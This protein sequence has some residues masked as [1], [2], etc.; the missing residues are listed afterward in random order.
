MVRVPNFGVWSLVAKLALG[1]S[2]KQNLVTRK[3]LGGRCS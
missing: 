2:T 3:V 1:I